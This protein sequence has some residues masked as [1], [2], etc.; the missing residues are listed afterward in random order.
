M[1][2]PKEPKEKKPKKV[3]PP[4]EKKPK[5]PKKGQAPAEDQEGQEGKKKKKFPILLLIPIIVLVVVA[6][7]V[8]FV[9]LPG[10][11]NAE[12]PDA[13]VSVEP[14]P[15][16]LPPEYQVGDEVVAGMTLGADESEAKAIP[17]KTVVYT[18]TD[19]V[20][21]GK[22]AETYAGQLSSADP[23]FYV[24]DEEFIRTDRP[25]FSAKEGT[26]LMARNIVVETPTPSPEP[27]ESPEGSEDDADASA[28]P[29][30]SPTPSAEP[31][32]EPPG[33]VLMVKMEWSEGQCKVTADQVEG[34][35]TSRPSSQQTPGGGGMGQHAAKDYLE[36]LTPGQLGLEGES[37]EDYEVMIVDG[38][39]LVNDEPC[40]RL[41]IYDKDMVIMGSYLIARDGQHMYLLD[42]L[43]GGV[44]EL[45]M[46]KTN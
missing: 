28:Q 34:K 14:E 16:S 2:K 31:V 17:A 12:D 22:A 44:T 41:N 38:I 13:E 7:V 23:R 3:K 9:L 29:D 43:D 21:A 27:E 37:M 8:V 15:P 35:V 32:E 10:K 25:D 24:V 11:D 30:P 19:L 18:Y 45:D 20:D 42:P 5:K 33:M 6:G 36:S 46:P 39:V 1:K 40:T 26:L 4:K